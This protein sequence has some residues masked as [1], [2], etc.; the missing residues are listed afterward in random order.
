MRKLLKW[1]SLGGVTLGILLYLIVLYPRIQLRN[2][3]HL[4]FSQMSVY[5]RLY[6]GMT[7]EEVANVL[8]PAG[9]NCGFTTANLRGSRCEFSDFWHVYEFHLDSNGRVRYKHRTARNQPFRD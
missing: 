8:T 9:I 1:S 3:L 7:P 4:P 5:D 6:V 2:R